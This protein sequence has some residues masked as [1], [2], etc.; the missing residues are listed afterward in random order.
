MFKW[1]MFDEVKVIVVFYLIGL[2]LEFYKVYMGLWS[3]SEKVF[4]KVWG[5]LL[6]S[7]FMYVSVVSYM[8]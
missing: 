8:C 3:Y 6:Y 4:I 7:G 2:V 1:E 5:V